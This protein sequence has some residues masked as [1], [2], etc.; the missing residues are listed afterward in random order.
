MSNARDSK[1]ED[2]KKGSTRTAAL[3]L[4][5]GLDYECMGK[6]STFSSWNQ[7]I[8]FGIFGTCADS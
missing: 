7:L 5:S 8:L 4:A 3:I 6:K 1:T 2:C